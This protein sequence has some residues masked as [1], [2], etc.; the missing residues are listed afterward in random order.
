M[1]TDEHRSP[2][3]DLGLKEGDLPDS[4]EGRR[5]TVDLWYVQVDA[6]AKDGAEA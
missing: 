5:T 6:A 3:T 4:H 1:N 2:N